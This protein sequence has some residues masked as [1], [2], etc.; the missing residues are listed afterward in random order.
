MYISPCL[1][2]LYV[3]DIDSCLITDTDAGGQIFFLLSHTSI[4]RICDVEEGRWIIRRQNNSMYP[5]QFCVSGKPSSRISPSLPYYLYQNMAWDQHYMKILPKFV[6][7][8]YYY[9]SRSHIT[10]EYCYPN[11][12]KCNVF[13]KY[14]KPIT[15][16][17]PMFWILA[18]EWRRHVGS[19][20]FPLV[21]GESRIISL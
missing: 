3:D 1:T 10:F 11:L 13:K 6:L 18:C 16:C 20:H 19:F 4:K 2:Y 5:Q 8:L 21:F 14:S 7:H 12:Y 17:G 15:N 9:S